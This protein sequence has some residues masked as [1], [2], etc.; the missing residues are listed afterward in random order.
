M[1]NILVTGGAGFIGSNFVHQLSKT[2]E[3]RISVLDSMT[4]A[5]RKSNL[6]PL[7]SKGQIKFI[8]GNIQ[9]YRLVRELVEQNDLIV[10]FAAETH[11]D[12]SINAPDEFVRTNI[13]GVASLLKCIREF[14]KRMIQVSTDEVYGSLDKGFADE[15]YALKTNSPY[16][17]SKA[18]ADLLSQAY[19]KTYGVNVTITRCSNNYGI[20][21]HTEKFIPLSI[22]KMLQL[23]KVP[24]Y[25][26]GENVRNWIHVEDH[27]N[28]IIAVIRS[29][30]PGEIYNFGSF[31]SLTNLEILSLLS[32]F[33]NVDYDYINYVEDRK[34]H[35]FRYAI[36]FSK[37]MNEL[38]WAPKFNLEESLPDIIEWYEKTAR[39]VQ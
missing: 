26:T 24:V 34:G 10:N 31:E 13:L 23:E 4:Y 21:Q 8:Q 36:D 9:D 25:G 33:L 17:A 2:S 12:N 29:G 15:T 14:D 20:R 22:M 35:D 37:S 30:A 27:I 32:E 5:G 38:N 39:S 16:S 3:F 7:I 6:E 1:S 11:V 19:F 28:G 18:S